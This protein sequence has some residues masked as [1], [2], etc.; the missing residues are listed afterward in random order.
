MTGAWH[1]QLPIVIAIS[2]FSTSFFPVTNSLRFYKKGDISIGF[3][4]PIHEEE[5]PNVRLSAPGNSVPVTPT[6][7]SNG[8]ICKGK[9]INQRAFMVAQ[10]RRIIDEVNQDPDILNGLTLG[11]Q[12]IDSCSSPDVAVAETV[13]WLTAKS[14]AISTNYTFL[15]MEPMAFVVGAYYSRITVPLAGLLQHLKIPMVSA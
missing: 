10:F 13:P 6:L 12:I 3:V 14:N 15:N 5:L 1:Q 4:L 9:L 8:T 2:V 11:Y 7:F